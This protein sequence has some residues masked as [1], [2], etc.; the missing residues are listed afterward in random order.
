MDA[1]TV[2]TNDVD[3]A[4]AE[5]GRVFCP[6]Q[7]TPQAGV[8]SVQLRMAARRVGGVGV[9][10]LDYGQEVQIEPPPLETFYLVQ[11]P[12]AGSAMVRHSG[13]TVASTPGTASV[14]SPY[15]PSHM[16]WSEG[17]PHR[18]FYADRRAVDRELARLLGRAVDVPVRFDLAMVMTTSTAQA[19]ARGVAFLADELSQPTDASLFDHPQ[20][21]ARFEEGLI[22]KLLLTHRHSQSDLLVEPGHHPNPGR[23]VRRACALISDHHSEA[24]T[25]GDVAEALRVSV[26]TLQD[27]FRRE[28]HT[29]P[30]AYLRAYRLDAAHRTLRSAEPGVSV[31]T[32]ALQHGFVHLGRFATEY[33]ARFGESPSATL[34]R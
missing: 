10:D 33:R 11:I 17:T 23:L 13:H 9:I 24:L 3:Q 8:R 20:V 5:V 34:R 16:R 4:R 12:R 1:V 2:R 30:T 19:W 32:V 14:L 25:V 26:R 21:A 18:I 6:H 7:L 28:L 29:T 22:G 15:E 27:C 31:T